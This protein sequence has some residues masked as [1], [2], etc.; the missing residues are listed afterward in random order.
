MS[1][2]N[3]TVNSQRVFVYPKPDHQPAVFT[4]LNFVIET[5]NDAIDDLQSRGVA[6][7]R[8]DNLPTEQDRRGVLRGKVAG[9]GPNIAWFKDPSG[10]ILALVEE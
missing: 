8:Y 10:N 3:F 6:F 4:V 7:E 5:I 1:R 2:F 9:M